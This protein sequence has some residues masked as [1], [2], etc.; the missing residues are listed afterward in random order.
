M[1]QVL[2]DQK[3]LDFTAETSLKVVEEYRAKYAWIDKCL[4]DNDL[5]VWLV[6]EDLELLSTSNGGRQAK[7]T[8]E[9]L[10][11]ALLVHQIECTSLRD[12]VI[13]I[14]ESPTLQSF[15]RLGN[16]SVMDF[17]FLNRAF[18]AITPE[19]W[20]LVN[21]E[22]AEH[23]VKKCDVDVSRIRTDSTV[24]ETNIHYPTDSSLLWDSYR[25]LSR[26]LRGVRDE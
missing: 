10:F 6:H 26:L 25:V 2:D 23:A 4:E 21:E 15:I 18:K 5:I 14:A 22:L 20:K 9:I 13:R 11:R 1:P 24:I 17:T 3:Y 12:T 19:T 7:Y 8:T 16:R